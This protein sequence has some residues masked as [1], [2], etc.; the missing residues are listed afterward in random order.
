MNQSTSKTAPRIAALAS[1]LLGA[2]PIAA[3]ASHSDDFTVTDGSGA[4]VEQLIVTE[5]Q[6]LIYGPDHVYTLNIAPDPSQWQNWTSL[7]TDP[8]NPTITISDIF[9]VVSFDNGVTF[10][11]GFNSDAEDALPFGGTWVAPHYNFWEDSLPAF[12]A[13]MYL[14]LD[15]QAQEYHA[16]FRSDNAL[17]GIPEPASLSLLSIGALSMFAGTR[18]S[19]RWGQ[20]RARSQRSLDGA[21]LAERNP[22]CS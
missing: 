7:Y 19:R 13:T 12:D 6:E 17:N 2:L 9:G 20:T 15:L 22:G 10:Q 3:L 14:S 1:F 16:Y 8:D 5:E 4:I 21:E 11:L 18:K